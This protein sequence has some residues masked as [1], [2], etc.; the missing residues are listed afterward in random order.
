MALSVAVV[1]KGYDSELHRSDF[2]VVEEQQVTL[3]VTT[4]LDG[5]AC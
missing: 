2:A 5:K 3:A 1:L 4:A